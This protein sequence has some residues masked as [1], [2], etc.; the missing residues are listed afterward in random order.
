[1]QYFVDIDNP[2]GNKLGGGDYPDLPEFEALR[3]LEPPKPGKA[4]ALYEAYSGTRKATKLPPLPVPY[5]TFADT[6][7][8]GL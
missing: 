2:A 6:F 5:E 8:Y 7:S 4:E 3:G 1:M